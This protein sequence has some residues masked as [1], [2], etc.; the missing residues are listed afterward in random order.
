MKQLLGLIVLP[1]FG[2]TLTDWL[3]MR[4]DINGFTSS[5]VA[6]HGS[7]HAM[8]INEQVQGWREQQLYWVEVDA[9]HSQTLLEAL[10]IDYPEVEIHYWLLP[11]AAQGSLSNFMTD[12]L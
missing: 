9:G 3:L 6:G 12:S 7:H 10:K 2:E 1:E 11:L 4:E 8:S 5:P